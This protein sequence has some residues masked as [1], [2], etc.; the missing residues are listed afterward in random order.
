M[1]ILITGG[2]GFVGSTLV[3]LLLKEGLDV[4]VVD[5]LMYHQDSL[6]GNAMFKNFHFILGDVRDEIVMKPA[7]R[8][9][10]VIIH[11]A[12]IVGE[13]ACRMRPDLAKS[14]NLQASKIINKLRSKNQTLIFA[15]T[16]SNYGKVRTICTEKT[17]LNPLSLYGVTKTES[18]KIFLT[19]GN[20]II[21]RFATGFGISPRLRLDLLPND[22]TYK[23]V[24]E[25]NLI[26]Y[27]KD[28]RRTFIHVK[29]MAKAFAFALAHIPQMKNDVFNVGH[30]S[31]NLT[32]E[33]IAKKIK[34]KID[35]YLYFA[36]IG[37]D[38]DFRNYEVSYKKIRKIGFT[39][40]ISIDEGLEELIKAFKM[41]LVVSPHS[42]L[43]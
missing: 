7:I 28:Y 24:H 6:L 29:D 21:Y 35:F 17:P 41:I 37:H 40:D 33:N 43:N 22:F 26:V 15:S 12:A 32:K 13:P 16:G 5:N 18:E 10:D 14:V 42:N 27:Q 34:E 25:R 38:P 30:E 20:C 11:L 19:K 31:M 1:K 8:N 2:A 3:P 4:T 9:A 23:A 39:T 36:P